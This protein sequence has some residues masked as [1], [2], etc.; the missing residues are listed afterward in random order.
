MPTRLHWMVADAETSIVVESTAAGLDVY[1]NP[2]GVMTN[3]PPFPRQLAGWQIRE[4]CTM[5]YCASYC[6]DVR[7][8]CHPLTSFGVPIFYS[9]GTQG[10][11]PGLMKVSPYR[12]F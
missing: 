4:P 8:V 2:I 9:D 6:A 11:R 12:A 7:L 10:L 1:D 3:E 5:F